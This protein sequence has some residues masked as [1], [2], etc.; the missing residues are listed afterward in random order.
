MMSVCEMLIVRYK[1]NH[2]IH[3]IKIPSISYSTVYS[4]PDEGVPELLFHVV[5]NW[6]LILRGI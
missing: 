4:V 2:M 3:V 6:L 1:A 5:L